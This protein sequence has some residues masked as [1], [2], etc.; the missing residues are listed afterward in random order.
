MNLKIKLKLK[1]NI[2]TLVKYKDDFRDFTPTTFSSLLDNFFTDTVKSSN[3]K[4]FFPK[5]DVAETEKAFVINL[6]APG[7]KKE[8]FSLEVSDGQLTVTG[9]R[10]F[11]N[12]EEGKVYHTVETQYGAFTKSFH[13]P[14]NI[15][16]D[17]IDAKYEDGMLNIFLPK[18]EK[19]LLKNSIKV[20]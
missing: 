15:K 20:K 19:K 13:L 3:V 2:M 18:D 10:T 17:K 6:A 5:V 7:M 8:D 16:T 11:V 1:N 9:E 12:D 4:T 14:D